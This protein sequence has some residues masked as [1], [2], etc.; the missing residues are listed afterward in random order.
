MKVKRT[1]LCSSPCELEL[2]VLGLRG[3]ALPETWCTWGLAVAAAVLRTSE[4]KDPC[5]LEGEVMH[6][7]CL[8]TALL[9]QILFLLSRLPPISRCIFP[10][11]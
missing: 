9:F 10:S 6:S 8:L 4:M 1:L 2:G 3:G 5:M 11:D 7:S